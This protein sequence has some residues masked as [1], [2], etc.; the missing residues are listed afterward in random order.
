MERKF[1]LSCGST[2]DLPYSYMQKRDIPVIFYTYTVNEKE[3]IDDMGRDPEALSRFY[4]LL[5]SGIIPSTSQINEEK[6][7][8][9]FRELLKKG[10]VLH[11][12]FGSG[13]SGSVKNA[14]A[15]KP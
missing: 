5:D 10:D 8:E 2:V 13:M 7:A 11:L 15:A 3:Y 12:A 1:I 4:S 6:Y 9:F 14:Q